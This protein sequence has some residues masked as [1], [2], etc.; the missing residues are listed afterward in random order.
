[1]F[2]IMRIAVFS[3]VVIAGIVPSSVHA[4]WFILQTDYE[5]CN[6]INAMGN[7]V[8]TP[9]QLVEMMR[10]EGMNIE[11][12]DIPQD[13]WDETLPVNLDDFQMAVHGGGPVLF[14]RGATQ[15]EEMQ[16]EMKRRGKEQ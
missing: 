6:S 9:E 11:L 12:V 4:D 16:K 13:E 15:C 14:V 5:A 8:D 2:T 3:S 10:S 1:M 7:N